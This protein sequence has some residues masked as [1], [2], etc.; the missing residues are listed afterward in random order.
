MRRHRSYLY[1]DL[2][3][4]LKRE[5][6]P[7]YNHQLPK[8]AVQAWLK[9]RVEMRLYAALAGLFTMSQ[10]S[11]EGIRRDKATSILPTEFL[12]ESKEV[13]EEVLYRVIYRGYLERE[14]RQI[15]KLKDAERIRIPSS[16]DYATIPGLRRESALKLQQLRPHN[17]GQASRISGVNPADIGILMVRIAAGHRSSAD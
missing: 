14:H 2:S 7:W 11:A 16:I 17:L 6:A 5:L 12:A 15:E 3:P 4:S 13:R 8:N 9:N 1:T 10:W